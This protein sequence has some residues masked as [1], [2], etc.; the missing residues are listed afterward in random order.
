PEELTREKEVVIEEIRRGEDSPEGRLSKAL[1]HLAF[2]V[3]PYGRPII[4]FVDNVRNVSRETVVAFH[5]RWY[6][7]ANMVLVVSGDFSPA[8]FKP[9]I[10]KFFGPAIGKKVPEITR[11]QEPAQTKSAAEV[12]RAD[13]KTAR[14]SLA[15]HIPEFSSD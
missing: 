14:L 10:E 12:L 1:F 2:Q 6:Q 9:A 5:Q 4:G 8:D 11:P 7:P 3:H 13:V 15:F